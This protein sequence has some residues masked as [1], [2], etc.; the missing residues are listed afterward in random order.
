SRVRADHRDSARERFRD[1]HA[2]SLMPS[3]QHEKISGLV[4]AFE[5][6]ARQFTDERDSLIEPGSM[7]LLP[8]SRDGRRASR[9][10]ATA[11]KL[12]GRRRQPGERIDEQVVAFTRRQRGHAKQMQVAVAA[13]A[14]FA[15]IAAAG[16]ASVAV[17]ASTSVAVAA[18]T[19]VAVAA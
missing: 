16:I 4:R 18:S 19:S 15:A 9:E 10:A 2:I 11:S 7:D 14:A 17:A 5:R 6:I 13:A 8:Q 1:G 12:P 3:R